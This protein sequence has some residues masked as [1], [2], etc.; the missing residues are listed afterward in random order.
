MT[1]LSERRKQY[2][3]VLEGNVCV[4]PASVFDAMSARMAE[5]LGFEVLMFAGSIASGTVLGAPDLVVLTLTEF[6]AQI[7]RIT[8][9][10]DV[11]LMVDADHGYGNA[12]NV[13]RTVEE[14]ES[15]GVAGL[16]IED[17]VLPAPFGKQGE[18]LVSLEEMLGKLRAAVAARQ[19][20]SLV[21]IGRTQALRDGGIAE[22]EK[23]VR[24]YQETGVD[25]IFLAGASKRE[26]V[27]AMH[28]AARLPLIVGGAPPALADRA[29]LAANGV[30]IALQG[31]HP[32]YAAAKAVYD[33]LKY[34]REGGAP[35]GLKDCVASE[36]LLAV[37]LKQND[38]KRWQGAYLR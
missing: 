32:F 31:H 37:A 20:P 27:E 15:A 4:H 28:R 10:S 13:M 34:L 18:G 11:P 8:R 5:S 21:V 38:Y 36:E 3:R 30:R 16:T 26:E 17:T 2:R 29:F 1:L 24:A 14:L 33:T 7:R 9:G 35:A 23:R 12:L 19:D 6:A 25:A 22:A